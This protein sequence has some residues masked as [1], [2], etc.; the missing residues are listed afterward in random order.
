MLL[1]QHTAAV[2]PH[3]Q[4]KVT[5]VLQC[6]AVLSCSTVHKLND[7]LQQRLL[8]LQ[9]LLCLTPTDT[10]AGTQTC[11][12]VWTPA[13]PTSCNQ[14][15]LAIKTAPAFYECSCIIHTQPIMHPMPASHHALPFLAALA[16]LALMRARS[17]SRLVHPAHARGP[18]LCVAWR[19]P[20]AGQC[21]RPAHGHRRAGRL[22][23]LCLRP[24]LLLR[25]ACDD[26]LGLLLS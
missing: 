2:K 22:G 10:L 9:G 5:L 12:T 3:V 7:C 17:T 18:A 16:R 24:L 13:S 14:P 19:R 6:P 26:R 1:R 23:W 15:H 8:S 21:G 11:C 25:G 20:L 4:P